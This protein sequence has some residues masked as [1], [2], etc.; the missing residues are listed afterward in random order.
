MILRL[1]SGLTISIPPAFPWESRKV[2]LTI[3]NKSA[4]NPY[5]ITSRLC[6]EFLDHCIGTF[7]C[8]SLLDVGCGSGILAIAAAAMGVPFVVGLDIDARAINASRFNETKNHLKVTP[9]W[10]LGTA[11]S[12]RGGFECVVANL[13][14]DILMEAAADLK[15]LLLPGGRLILSGF[16]DIHFHCVRQDILSEDMRIEKW[17]SGDLSFGDVPPSGS[18]TWVAVQAGS[19]LRSPAPSQ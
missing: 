5:H 1:S 14:F 11:A 18:Y 13:P 16:H 3:R 7:H 8:R 12:I 4:F 2:D 10:I 19:D 6:L 15:R 17:S 9:H